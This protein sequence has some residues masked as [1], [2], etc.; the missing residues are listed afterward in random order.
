MKF[1]KKLF[2]PHL[3]RSLKSWHVCKNGKEIET[4]QICDFCGTIVHMRFDIDD[5]DMFEDICPESP[6]TKKRYFNKFKQW[7]Y[8]ECDHLNIALRFLLRKPEENKVAIEEIYF[9]LRKVNGYFYDDVK[10]ALI[11]NF[12]YS[13]E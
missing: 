9:A 2:C 5:K 6:K 12:L 4:D 13:F 1:F 11:E 7:A 3:G 10:E 8:P